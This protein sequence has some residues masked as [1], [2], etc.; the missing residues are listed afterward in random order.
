ML[1]RE[2]SFYPGMVL[3]LEGHAKANPR[4]AEDRL[5]V[6][7]LDAGL[8]AD[9]ALPLRAAAFLVGRCEPADEATA[10]RLAKTVAGLLDRLADEVGRARGVAY[11]EAAMSVALNDQFEVGHEA[12]LP[13]VTDRGAATPHAYMAAAYLAE[14]GDPVGW[15][16][17]RAALHNP[18]DPYTRLQAARE[19]ATFVPYD[20][21]DILD[22]E[23]DLG[24]ELIARLG[25]EDSY[26]AVSVPPLIVQVGPRDGRQALE[27][28]AKS[29][30]AE[31][32]RAAA[33]AALEHLD[34]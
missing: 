12:L 24:A 2:R 20:G 33:A 30:P 16:A 19:L 15:P 11:I 6:S 31:D 5:T 25:D 18:N 13:L 23:I 26:V 8:A 9:K 7:M 28:A 1:A 21:N 22:E 17:L 29:A 32:V 14:M 4:G 34:S 3:V 10:A 27:D